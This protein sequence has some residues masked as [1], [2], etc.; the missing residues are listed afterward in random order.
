[1]TT[2][3]RSDEWFARDA[4]QNELVARERLNEDRR[5]TPE[6]R[7]EMTLRLSAALIELSHAPRRDER[8]PAR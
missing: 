2:E 6:E 3:P 1:M 7:L 4:K 8:E 5:R